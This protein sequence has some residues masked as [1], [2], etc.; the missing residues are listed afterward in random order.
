MSASAQ[1]LT[2]ALVGFCNPLLDIS[3][4][5]AE[6]LLKKYNLKANDAILA[7]DE[8]KPLYDDLVTN[9]NPDFVVGGA[10]QNTLRGAQRLLPP[11]FTIFF[12]AVGNDE[13]GRRLRE[14]ANKDGL[15]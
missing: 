8:H 6:E 3:V 2:G 15:E 12:G 1:D 13:N 14:A 10:G 7:G 11:K 9:Y 5:N 4:T